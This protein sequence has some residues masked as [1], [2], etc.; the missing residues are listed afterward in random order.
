MFELRQLHFHLAFVRSS[1]LSEDVEDQPGA[2]DH[3][4]AQQLLKVAFLHRREQM[5]D[6]HQIC[7]ERTYGFGHLLGFAGPD[8]VTRIRGFDARRN[9]R[10]HFC[11]SRLHQFDEFFRTLC[12]IA[13]AAGMRED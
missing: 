4:S 2:I 12:R 1:A 7:V 8:V 6:Q 13:L 3:A 10:Q 9:R 5:V 11:A